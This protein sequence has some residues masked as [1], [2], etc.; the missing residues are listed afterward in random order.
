MYALIHNGNI[1]VG[2]RDYQRYFFSRYLLDNGI[3]EANL[4]PPAKN[5]RVVIEGTGWQLKPVDM[6]PASFNEMTE[7]PVGPTNTIEADR[8]LS[9]YGVTDLPLDVAKSKAK[10]I[11]A[12]NR[13]DVEVGGMTQTV[14]SQEVKV[15]TDRENRN[16]YVQAMQ[17][18]TENA[19]IT[20]KFPL[21][22]DVWLNLTKPDLVGIVGTIMAH[23]QGAYS[24]E[25][26]KGQEIDACT[27]K[28]QLEAVELRHPSQIV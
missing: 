8:V 17:L 14:Q 5:D 25:S 16:T 28:A 22:G 18:M 4:L 10:A 1:V 6:V 23:V 12:K 26:T 9:V 15:Y 20:W 13:Y 27:T 24:W 11:V 21:S 3:N 2:P 7:Q 19:V